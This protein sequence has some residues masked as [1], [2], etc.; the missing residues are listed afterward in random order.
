ML[1]SQQ[2]PLESF[3]ATLLDVLA[4][5]ESLQRVVLTLRAHLMEEEAALV[6]CNEEE[7][8]ED[9]TQVP[10]LGGCRSALCGW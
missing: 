3:Y 9:D 1:P 5:E 2:L 8:E 10:Y 7:E 6:V 4:L